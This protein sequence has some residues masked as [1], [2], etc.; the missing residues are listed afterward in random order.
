MLKK[1][2]KLTLKD[3]VLNIVEVITII[4]SSYLFYKSFRKKRNTLEIDKT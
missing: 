4:F 1:E 3:Y 2:T